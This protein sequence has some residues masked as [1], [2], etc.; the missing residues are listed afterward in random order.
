MQ[1]GQHV[2]PSRQ[3]QAWSRGGLHPGKHKHSST[4]SPTCVQNG[5][6]D[7]FLALPAADG[8][9]LL[10]PYVEYGADSCGVG[11]AVC[12]RT[13]SNGNEGIVEK[14]ARTKQQKTQRQDDAFVKPPSA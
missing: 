1:T 3:Y 13:C 6:G 2:L 11:F 7:A 5:A 10:S 9:S 4:S 12:D 14:G 8:R